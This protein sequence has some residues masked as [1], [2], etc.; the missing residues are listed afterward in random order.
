MRFNL[1]Y[2]DIENE[3]GNV[4]YGAKF[5]REKVT[6]EYVIIVHPTCLRNNLD[7]YTAP[8]IVVPCLM[9]KFVFVI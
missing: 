9:V 8:Y 7:M 4:Q 5:D 2:I 6:I 1:F 3:N